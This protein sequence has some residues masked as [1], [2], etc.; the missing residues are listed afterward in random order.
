MEASRTHSPSLS[1]S[2]GGLKKVFSKNKRNNSFEDRRSSIE[3]IDRSPN[4]LSHESSHDGSSKSSS[5][6]IAKLIPGHSKR[7]SRRRRASE[8]KQPNEEDRGRT[9][10]TFSNTTLGL[11][12][13]PPYSGNH[14]TSSLNN[15]GGSSLLTDDSEPERYV[16]MFPVIDGVFAEGSTIGHRAR[17]P[18]PR[19][20]RKLWRL[21]EK[22]P[23]SIQI[24]AEHF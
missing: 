19:N 23:I 14:S 3:S 6:G 1:T 20:G 12:V 18:T 7:K 13:E 10:G 5:N 2:T 4:R 17:D 9:E 11:G 15:D 16:L 21:H 24:I 8:L 22:L